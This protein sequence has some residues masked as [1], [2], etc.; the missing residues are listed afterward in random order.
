MTRTSDQLYHAD[1]T[2]QDYIDMA[3]VEREDMKQVQVSP[4]HR[5]AYLNGQRSHHPEKL[6]AD[7]GTVVFGDSHG[8]ATFEIKRSLK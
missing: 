8:L 7:I 1:W 6:V 2:L 4:R 5:W 3:D